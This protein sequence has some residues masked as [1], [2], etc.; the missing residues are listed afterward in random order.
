GD[1]QVIA[2]ACLLQEGWDVPRTTTVVLAR[3]FGTAGG[4]IQACGRALRLWPGKTSARIVDLRGVSHLHGAI[5]APRSWHLEGRA[6]R[7]PGDNIDAKFC[8][9]CGNIVTDASCEECGHAGEMRQRAPR[10]LGLPM[11]RF[12]TLR[13]EPDDARVK[14]LARWMAS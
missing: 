3:G 8:P 7:R 1:L 9:V 12:A 2:N 4:L 5:D 14:R 6:C 10:V 13:A 11:Q